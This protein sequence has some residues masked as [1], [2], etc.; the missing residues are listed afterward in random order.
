MTMICDTFSH[1]NPAY[2]SDEHDDFNPIEDLM[3]PT[4]ANSQI[5]LIGKK[6]TREN[7]P[8]R[9]LIEES[10]ADEYNSAGGVDSLPQTS[11]AKRQKL[12][13]N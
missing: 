1:A 11:P 12:D 4:I 6:R 7:D 10:S 3:P 13:Q 5:D 2:E 9:R 8:L